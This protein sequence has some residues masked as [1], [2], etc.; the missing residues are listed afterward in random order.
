MQKS[1]RKFIDIESIS[2]LELFKMTE[3]SVG[4]Y[5]PALDENG[6]YHH[7]IKVISTN[8]KSYASKVN[9]KCIVE[10]MVMMSDLA[11]RD[12][13]KPSKLVKIT[14]MPE[15]YISQK[16]NLHLNAQTTK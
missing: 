14:V 1:S 10:S 9:K 13:P 8:A 15:N 4:L 12:L 5:M 16:G 2:M 3:G 11:T 6:S 7:P